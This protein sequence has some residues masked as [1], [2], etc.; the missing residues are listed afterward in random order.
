MRSFAF[1]NP[2]TAHAKE[3]GNTQVFDFCFGA[4]VVSTCVGIDAGD[5]CAESK[6]GELAPGELLPRGRI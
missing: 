2:S 1:G 5:D 3:N 4:L 6:P